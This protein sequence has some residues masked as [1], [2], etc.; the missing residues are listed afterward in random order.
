MTDH[1]RDRR[2]PGL[3]DLAAPRRTQTRLGR[4][5]RHHQPTSSRSTP[6]RPCHRRCGPRTGPKPTRPA[7]S[8]TSAVN[9]PRNGRRH[10]ITDDYVA[11]CE[12]RVHAAAAEH[13]DRHV[14]L[15]LPRRDDRARIRLADPC[16]H[17]RADGR[18]R[19][20]DPTR[21]RQ[22]RPVRPLRAVACPAPTATGC[23]PTNPVTTTWFSRA[24][25]RTR[26]STQ[27]ASNQRCC[28]ACRRRTHYSAEGAA[29]RSAASSCPEL[30]F[31]EARLL[32][33]AAT[34]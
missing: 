12:R 32:R 29:T 2:H 8:P 17:R 18:R 5:R 22:H 34:C 21:Q 11:D 31:A 14:G 10:A 6:G 9:S 23:G 27:A 3:S 16:L 33:Y 13:L 20:R 25:G 30:P 4:T 19:H 24:T 1:I 7:P 26:G 15:Y 28:P